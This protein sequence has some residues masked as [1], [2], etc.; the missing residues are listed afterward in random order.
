MGTYTVGR[1]FKSLGGDGQRRGGGRQGSQ[2]DA[3][4]EFICKN[5]CWLIWILGLDIDQLTRLFPV[6]FFLV[7]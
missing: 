4:S 2:G 1:H 6:F 7:L 3:W 5:M